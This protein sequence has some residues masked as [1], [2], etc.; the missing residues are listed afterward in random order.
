MLGI[1][2]RKFYSFLLKKIDKEISS[3]E[4]Y[5]SNDTFGIIRTTIPHDVLIERIDKLREEIEDYCVNDIEDYFSFFS[6]F[7]RLFFLF[8]FRINFF[9]KFFHDISLPFSFLDHFFY[10]LF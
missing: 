4:L 3:Y 2:K 1:L 7:Y 6:L 10:F 9:L 5:D 8:I